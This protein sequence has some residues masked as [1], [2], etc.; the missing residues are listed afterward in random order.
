MASYERWLAFG[1]IHDKFHGRANIMI[2]GKHHAVV[3]KTHHSVPQI[4]EYRHDGQHRIK[5]LNVG[6]GSGVKIQGARSS[7]PYKTG[8]TRVPSNIWRGSNKGIIGG[9]GGLDFG[10]INIGKINIRI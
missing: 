4:H 9:H 10:K 2:H 1:H 6:R 3:H 8:K 7:K 5:F